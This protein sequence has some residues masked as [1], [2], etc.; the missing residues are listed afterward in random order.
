M[1]VLEPDEHDSGVQ[2][3]SSLRKQNEPGSGVHGPRAQHLGFTRMSPHVRESYWEGRRRLGHQLGFGSARF[4]KDW[5]SRGSLVPPAMAGNS[6]AAGASLEE[7]QVWPP[8][9]T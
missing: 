5:A 7:E 4:P 9:L 6:R 1:F 3:P 8:M 2:T